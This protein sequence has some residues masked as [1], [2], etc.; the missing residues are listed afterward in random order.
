VGGGVAVVTTADGDAPGDGV[1]IVAVAEAVVSGVATIRLDA[2]T[3]EG[4]QLTLASN[5]MARRSRRITT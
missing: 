4:A 2:T 1:M 3:L 5:P